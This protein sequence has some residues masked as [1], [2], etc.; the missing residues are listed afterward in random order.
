M[1]WGD[2]GTSNRVF[3]TFLTWLS[4]KISPVFVVAT[5]NNIYSLPL[6]IL[7]KGRFDEIFFIGLPNFEE[8]KIIFK[9]QLST[10]RP[11]TWEVYDL[12]ELS[13]KTNYFSGAEIK[14]A[15]IEGMHFAFNEKRDFTTQDIKNGIKEIIPLAQVDPIRTQDLQ[16][17]A[18]SGRIRIASNY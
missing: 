9:I 5:A 13:L 8:R 14:Q 15:I 4:E 16:D 7:R 11:K 10:F 18:F 2:S 3:S 6:E 12:N 17:W 1:C